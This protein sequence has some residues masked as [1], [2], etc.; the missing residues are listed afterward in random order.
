MLIDVSEIRK[1]PGRSFHFDFSEVIELIEVGNDR[2]KFEKPVSISLD[3][4][5]TGRVLNF[6]GSIQGDTVLICSRCLE[7]Y[8]YHLNAGFEEKFVH[9]SDVSAAAEEGQ[10]TEEMHVFDGNSIKLD[11]IIGES[12]ILNI[13]MKQVCSENCQGLC[14]TCGTNLNKGECNCKNDEIDPRLE[15]LKKFFER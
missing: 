12:I 11:D 6:A 9:A 4:K 1:S 3:V 7:N 15:G 13:P 10:N 8:P 2:I 14:S 5:N